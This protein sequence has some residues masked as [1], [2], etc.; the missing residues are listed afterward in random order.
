MSEKTNTL[1]VG[2]KVNFIKYDAPIPEG[3]EPIFAAGD[4]LEITSVPTNPDSGY[5]AIVVGD[6]ETTD[7]VFPEEVEAALRSHPKVF[8][9]L[10]VGVPDP[11]FGSRVAA[12]VAPREGET[13]TLED[14]AEHCRT[15]IAGYKVPRELHLADQIQRQPSGKPD[16]T[17]AKAVALGVP[18]SLAACPLVFVSQKESITVPPPPPTRPPKSEVPVTLPVE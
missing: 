10:V 12:V 18:P 2:D 6:P 4:S 15:H 13:L 3:Q 1:S 11:R 5:G 17:W 9:A 14:L 8:D 7:Q 16:Y